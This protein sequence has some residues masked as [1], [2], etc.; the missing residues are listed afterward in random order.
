ML[1][2]ILLMLVGAG[3]RLPRQRRARGSQQVAPGAG[4]GAG[5]GSTASDAWPCC[6]L[7]HV[8][9][10]HHVGNLGA[11]SSVLQA[12]RVAARTVPLGQRRQGRLQA[13]SIHPPVGTGLRFYGACL[14]N[15]L[16][17]RSIA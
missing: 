15:H 8:D 9:M 17:A 6:G 5:A 14:S 13:G 11:E 10:G 2:L 4:A 3:L 1:L 7:L 12:G 16:F